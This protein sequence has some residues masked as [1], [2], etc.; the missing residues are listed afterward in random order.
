VVGPSTAK[1]QFLRY[2]GNGIQYSLQDTTRNALFS[3]TSRVEKFVR[4]TA[5]DTVAVRMGAIMSALIVYVGSRAGWSTATFAAV[6][7]GLALAWLV[8]VVIIGNEHL[9]RSEEGEAAL[10][11]EPLP[12]LV[13]SVHVG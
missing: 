3:M 12:N 4:K 1:L 10:A 5:V 7:V 8:F 13:P 2:L 11:T 9:R 6:N